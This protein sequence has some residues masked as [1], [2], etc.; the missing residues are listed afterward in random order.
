MNVFVVSSDPIECARSL[1]DRRLIK[2]VLETAQLL[3]AAVRADPLLA[4]RDV[5]VDALYRATHL[6]HPVCLWVRGSRAAFAW[7]RR[8]LDALLAEYGHRFQKVHACSRI[9][10]LLG[11][12]L[13]EVPPQ[14]WCNCTNFPDLPVF[15]AYQAQLADKWAKDSRPP[16]WRGRGAPQWYSVPC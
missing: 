12:A 9:A 1:D 4:G 16:S 13:D 11:P 5:E 3:S 14:S 2:M 15:Q 6:N 7:T 10:D 8:L